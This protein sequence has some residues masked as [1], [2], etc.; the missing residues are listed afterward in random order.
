MKRKDDSSTPHSNRL[1]AG[2][3]LNSVDSKSGVGAEG[4]RNRSNGLD[5]PKEA[6]DRTTGKEAASGRVVNRKEALLRAG[7]RRVAKLMM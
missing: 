5:S 2:C 1:L 3:G 6:N 4:S 7:F